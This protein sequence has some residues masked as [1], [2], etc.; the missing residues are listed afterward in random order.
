MKTY[1]YS[2]HNCRD[3]TDFIFVNAS[4]G[5]HAI[6]KASKEW[7]DQKN[8]HHVNQRDLRATRVTK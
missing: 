4:S 6:K 5:R 3:Y 7:F 8:C 2:V 1:E